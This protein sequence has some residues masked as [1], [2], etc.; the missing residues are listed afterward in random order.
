MKL[1]D[2]LKQWGYHASLSEGGLKQHLEMADK[3]EQLEAELETQR[4]ESNRLYGIGQDLVEDNER[5][6]RLLGERLT[7][8][9]LTDEEKIA[10]RDG[11]ALSD[12]PC[13]P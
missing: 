7:S 2:E 10:A 13:S 9:P 3:A 6:R 8:D 4:T 1:S 12:T 5:L 11:A